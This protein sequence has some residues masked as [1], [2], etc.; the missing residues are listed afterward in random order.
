MGYPTPRSDTTCQFFPCGVGFYSHK[1]HM[2]NLRP[3]FQNKALS[4]SACDCS[5]SS[6]ELSD[7]EPIDTSSMRK[8]PISEQYYIHGRRAT[9]TIGNFFIAKS[10]RNGSSS[11]RVVQLVTM[12]VLG[13]ATCP[14]VV[15]Q[16]YSYRILLLFINNY[17]EHYVHF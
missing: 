11:I 1:S 2:S 16:A 9:E 7:R 15:R 5:I 6:E 4:L 13:V 14:A 17:W 3:R 8:L 10:D 12:V